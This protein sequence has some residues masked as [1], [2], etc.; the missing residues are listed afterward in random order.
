MSFYRSIIFSFVIFAIIT[1]FCFGQNFQNVNVFDSDIRGQVRGAQ[2][3]ELV[4]AATL[5][6][7][8]RSNVDSD[9]MFVIHDVAPGSYVVRVVPTSANRSAPV[10]DISVSIEGPKASSGPISGTVSAQNLA[11][12]P[13]KA[14]LKYLNKAQRYSEEGNLAKAIETLRNAPM[15]P[16]GAPYIHGSLGTEYLKAGQ[17][18]LAAPELEAAAQALPKDPIQHSNLAYLYQAQGKPEQAEKEIRLALALDPSS[19]KAHFLL[20]SILLDRRTGVDEAM[21]NLKFARKEV[22]SARFLLAQAYMLT[23]QKDAAQREISDFLEVATDAQ[24]AAAK[25]WIMRHSRPADK[26]SEPPK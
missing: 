3:V 1:G 8:S 12:P 22:P 23:G 20:G 19:P 4:D 6:S 14:A 10:E 9:G 16:A 21:A 13:S 26:T 5:T 25:Q 17:F 7:I 2:S 24:K 11:K 15:D 18:A